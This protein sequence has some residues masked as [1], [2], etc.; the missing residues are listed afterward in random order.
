MIIYSILVFIGPFNENTITKQRSLFIVGISG[1]F[2]E[3]TIT[4]GIIIFQLY[5]GQLLIEC[6]NIKF[7]C[8]IV[9]AVYHMYNFFKYNFS[10]TIFWKY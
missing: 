1:P 5:F 10:C 7:S 4:K 3:I 2:N 9:V 8:P 6:K